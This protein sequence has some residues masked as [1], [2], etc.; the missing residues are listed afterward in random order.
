MNHF[1]KTRIEVLFINILY[2][3]III[4]L[5]FSFGFIHLKGLSHAILLKIINH[6][7]ETIRKE[8]VRERN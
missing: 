2:L 7:R 5:Y 8:N 6:I 4:K 1:S 3:F